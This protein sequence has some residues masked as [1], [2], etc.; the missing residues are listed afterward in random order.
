MVQRIWRHA[1]TRLL[2]ALGLF[3]SALIS[4]CDVRISLDPPPTVE[5]GDGIVV[6]GDGGTLESV[7]S[8]VFSASEAFSDCCDTWSG[9]HD[10]LDKPSPDSN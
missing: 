3:L 2:L 5:Y 9:G 8:D 1:C 6:G 4:A 7:G 10:V